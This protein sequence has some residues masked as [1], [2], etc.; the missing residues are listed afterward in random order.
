M[1][2]NPAFALARARVAAEEDGE[3]RVW[4][5]GAR[6][7]PV[8]A[9]VAASA[10]KK[11]SPLAKFVI[12]GT[13][14]WTFELVLGHYIEFLKIAKQTSTRSYAE[15]TSDMIRHKGLAGVLDGYFPWGSLQAIAKG[16]VF[17]FGHAAARGA[18]HGRV[19]DDWAEIMAGGIGGGVQG[20]VLSPLLLLKTRVMTN[21]KFRAS[22]GMLETTVASARLGADIVRAEGPLVLM[23]GAGVF[24]GKRVADWTTR[25]FFAE[26]FEA[27]FARRAGGKQNLT[28][29]E[30]SA[31]S[32]LGGSASAMVTIPIDV[33][34]A[35]VQDA[36]KAGTKVSV[37]DVWKE[38]LRTGGVGELVRY[39]TRGYVARV[40]HV[41]LTTLLMKTGAKM[42]YDKYESLKKQV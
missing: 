33:L 14:A 21:P 8:R 36:N 30:K 4:G 6:P 29:K 10:G 37:I 24:S 27:M 1:L 39:S 16:A 25:F 41:A 26:K 34:V 28:W 31:S 23:K 13:C 2:R 19:R 38:K 18:L 40:A 5:T 7:Q 9:I 32:L 3:R 12:G 15:I 20:I 35:T 17:G 22:G 42:V 11:E